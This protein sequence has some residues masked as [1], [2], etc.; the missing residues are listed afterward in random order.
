MRKSRFTDKSTITSELANFVGCNS[1]NLVI[2]RNTTE[3]LDLII[4]DFME[5]RDEPI[6]AYQD[7]G[8]MG[9]CLNKLAKGMV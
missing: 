5:K 9:I 6:Y 1:K 8:A 4:M 7:Y 2:T 3:S